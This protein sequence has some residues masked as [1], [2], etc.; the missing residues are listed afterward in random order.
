VRFLVSSEGFQSDCSISY[1]STIQKGGDLYSPFNFWL[2][3]MNSLRNPELN[4]RL[5]TFSGVDGNVVDNA[6]S[7]K[8]FPSFPQAHSVLA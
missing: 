5:Y 6:V 4:I 3:L 2:S 1:I 8:C 7:V